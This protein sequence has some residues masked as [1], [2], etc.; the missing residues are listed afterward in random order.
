MRFTLPL[1]MFFI[2]YRISYFF[3]AW[4]QSRY[5]SFLFFLFFVYIFLE[6]TNSDTC[7]KRPTHFGVELHYRRHLDAATLLYLLNY[8]RVVSCRPL[9]SLT[10]PAEV[11][12]SF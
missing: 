6:A 7:Q 5:F 4:F 10:H 12:W 11:Q 3:F 9:S 1:A 2:S 8:T